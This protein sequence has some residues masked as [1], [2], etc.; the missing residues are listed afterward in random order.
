VLIQRANRVL[1][2]LSALA[3]STPR[4]SPALQT[5]KYIMLGRN[6]AK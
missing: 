6:A 2:I 1:V 5:R 4:G 3:M